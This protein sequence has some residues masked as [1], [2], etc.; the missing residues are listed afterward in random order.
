MPKHSNKPPYDSYAM[1]SCET[2][3]TDNSKRTCLTLTT[4]INITLLFI[5]D[6]DENYGEIQP[7]LVTE[8]DGDE[9]IIVETV[10]DPISIAAELTV[11]VQVEDK[12]TTNI[13]LKPILNESV[14]EPIH[15]VV[16]AEK[17]LYQMACN[18][19]V[20]SIEDKATSL[21]STETA[22]SYTST[23][24]QTSNQSVEKQLKVLLW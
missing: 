17:I 14:E 4:W 23:E 6:Y 10:S 3:R 9:L 7:E 2:S 20:T 16:V 11:K 15:F 19:D 8:D 22:G 13:E 24:E 5:D 21:E 1:R 12:L 18:V